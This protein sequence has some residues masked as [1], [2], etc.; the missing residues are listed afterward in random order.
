MKGILSAAIAMG[1]GAL[2]LLGYFLSPLFSVRVILLQWAAILA[3]VAVLVGAA[4][5]FSVHFAKIRQQPTRAA[6]SILVI[7]FL[8]ASFFFGV[9]PGFEKPSSVLLNS[10]MIPV[11]TS[12]MAV[13]AVSLIYASVRL[14]RW[15]ADLMAFVFIA[16]ALLI[17]AAMTPLPFLG[18]IPILSDLVRPFVAQVLA[19]GGA[20]GIL[21]GVALGT[22]TTGLRI[23][24]GA[25]RPYGSK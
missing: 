10:I 11:E 21:I 14:L 13:L 12:L 6:Y 18:E 23:L 3:G 4:N 2:I 9:V 19:A 16:T 20:R 7:V 24:L 15:R 5:L 1:I 8:L 17:L 22:L 25:D